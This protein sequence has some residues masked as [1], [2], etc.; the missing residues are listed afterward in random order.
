MSTDIIEIKNKAQKINTPF[1]YFGSKNK[2]ALQLCSEL[3]P[4]S[5]W[6][7][8]FC[9]SASLTLRKKP[10][11]IEIINDIDQ[12]IINF[13]DQLRN[14]FDLLCQ[15]INLTP[16]AEQ[17]L[18]NARISEDGLSPLERA[19]RFLVQAMMAV[20]GIFGNERGG[21]SYSDSYTRNQ[22][23]ARVNRWNNLPER[24]RPVAERLKKVRIENKDANKLIERF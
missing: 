12:E 16:Y 18:I 8:V 20:N 17:E 15:A 10:A 9:G 14:N 3:P 1:G 6:V 13:F 11:S 22:N 23:E 4:H 2:I 24:L 7:E 5:C 19:R 21:F